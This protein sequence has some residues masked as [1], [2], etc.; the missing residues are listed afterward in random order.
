M[1]RSIFASMLFA[2]DLWGPGEWERDRI[3]CEGPT[4][5]Q[6]PSLSYGDPATA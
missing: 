1:D 5:A 3:L 4:R 2:Y 6:D